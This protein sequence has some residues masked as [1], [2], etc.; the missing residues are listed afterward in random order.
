VYRSR[1]PDLRR[2]RR[3]EEEEWRHRRPRELARIDRR[4]GDRDHRRFDGR[5]RGRSYQRKITSVPDH[6]ANPTKWKKYDLTV[7][8]TEGLKR[9]GMSDD[10]VNKYAAFQFL[11]ELRERR[12]KESGEGGEDLEEGEEGKVVFRKPK[13]GKIEVSLAPEGEDSNGGA[14]GKEAVGTGEFGSSGV[15]KMPEYVVGGGEEQGVRRRIRSRGKIGKAEAV[16]T[17]PTSCIS[18]SHLAEEEEEED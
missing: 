3:H 1:S 9:S 8:G 6:V 5:H 17:K 15:L 10:Q 18:L 12:K 2:R 4:E 11:K 7:D 16:G 14:R 13:K